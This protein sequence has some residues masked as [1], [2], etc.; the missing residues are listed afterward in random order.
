MSNE[1][2]GVQILKARFYSLKEKN[3]KANEEMLDN[4]NQYSDN[5]YSETKVLMD[6]IKHSLTVLGIEVR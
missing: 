2:Y 1:N 5:C 3:M 4:P 6:E